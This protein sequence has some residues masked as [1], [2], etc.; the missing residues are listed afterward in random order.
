LHENAHKF[1]RVRLIARKKIDGTI[2]YIGEL[3]SALG[4]SLLSTLIQ[5]NGVV[6][7]DSKKMLHK[8][9]SRS[10][11]ISKYSTVRTRRI[12]ISRT[13]SSQEN[14]NTVQFQLH[15]SALAM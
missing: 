15:L 9:E 14:R 8:N 6:I 13:W 4:A 10:Y 11:N 5:S 12:K 2:H 3:V 7:V 1:V